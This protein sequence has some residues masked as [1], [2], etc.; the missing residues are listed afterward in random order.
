MS[1]VS[2]GIGVPI[3]RLISSN[4][5][6]IRSASTATCCFSRITEITRVSWTACK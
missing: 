2:G 1:P 5:A 3:R 6:A 4:S